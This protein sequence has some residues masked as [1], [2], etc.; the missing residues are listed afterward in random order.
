MSVIVRLCHPAWL[1]IFFFSQ[2]IED[3]IGIDHPVERG[4][5]LANLIITEQFNFRIFQLPGA[6]AGSDFR[7]FYNRVRNA[8]GEE[9]TPHDNDREGNEREDKDAVC[10][11]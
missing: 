4:L 11:A 2:G 3:L 6:H 7:Q 5:E 1:L 8:A 9:K 10:Q